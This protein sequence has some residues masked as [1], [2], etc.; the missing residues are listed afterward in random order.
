MPTLRSFGM[1]NAAV[2]PLAT[3]MATSPMITAI[4]MFMLSLSRP[5]FL[6][7]FLP[8]LHHHSLIS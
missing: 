2:A 6:L 4:A 8:F 7:G 5:T 3:T 1:M